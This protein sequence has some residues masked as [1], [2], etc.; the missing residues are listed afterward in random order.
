MSDSQ[1]QYGLWDDRLKQVV[2]PTLP[3]AAPTVP[4]APPLLIERHRQH[5]RFELGQLLRLTLFQ[6]LCNGSIF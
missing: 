3:T 6:E 5:N 4:M 2:E 1:Q